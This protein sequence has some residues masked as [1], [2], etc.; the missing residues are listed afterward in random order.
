V[1]N[2]LVWGAGGHGRVVA[3]IARANQYSVV[4]YADRDP[5]RFGARVDAVGAHV[6]LSERAIDEWLEKNDAGLLCLGIGDNAVR[7][8]G[9]KR[10]P[11]NRT[12]H[13][14]HPAALVAPSVTIGPGT[15]V[16]AGV[17]INADATIARCAIINSGAIVEHDVAVGDGAHVSPG[18]VMA[19]AS[20]AGEA[21][22]IG[23]GAIVLP[24]IRIGAGAIVG[25]GAVVL[26]DVAEGATVAGNPARPL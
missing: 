15:V 7:L 11:E 23:A 22:W 18:A 5:D 14:I 1:R 10:F 8:A 25:A 17:V 13:M 4:G 16:M 26:H 9:M 3:D 19:G 6:I 24:G 12:P 21:A 2:V 20:S